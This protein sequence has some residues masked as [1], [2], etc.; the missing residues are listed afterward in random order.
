MRF[1]SRMAA[2]RFLADALLSAGNSW[3]AA[4]CC[5]VAHSSVVLDLAGDAVRC[6]ATSGAK[7][8]GTAGKRPIGG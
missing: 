8:G 5:G 3:D 6:R 4:A 7:V 2:L 1:S